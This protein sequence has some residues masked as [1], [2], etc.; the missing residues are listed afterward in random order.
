MSTDR[1]GRVRRSSSAGSLG[2][3]FDAALSQYVRSV[4][5]ED[6]QDVATKLNRFLDWEFESYQP[7]HRA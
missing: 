6:W 1:S 4:S 2:K 5:G 7:Y 3:G